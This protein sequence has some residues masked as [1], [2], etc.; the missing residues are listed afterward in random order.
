[1][2]LNAAEQYCVRYR[3]ALAGWRGALSGVRPE[4]RSLTR[5]EGFMGMQNPAPQGSIQ[6]SGGNYFRRQSHSAELVAGR[7]LDGS[8]RAMAQFSRSGSPAEHNAEIGVV[9]ASPDQIRLAQRR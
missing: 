9:D 7:N 3:Q 8:E 5:L 2:V 6:H 4:G 1:M